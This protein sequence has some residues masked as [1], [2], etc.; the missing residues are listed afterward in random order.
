MVSFSQDEVPSLDGGVGWINSGPIELAKL[1]GKIVLLD[2]WTYCCINCHHVLPA[3]AKLEQKYKNELVVIGVHSGKFNAERNTENIRRKV[4]EY[5][6]KHPVV[7]DA[8]MTIWERFGR[9]SWPTLVLIDPDGQE[10]G[11]NPGEIPF[12]HPRPRDRPGCRELQRPAQPQAAR[13][14]SRDGQGRSAGPLLFPGKVLADVKGKRLFISD[15]G[16]NR[17]VQTDLEGKAPVVIGSGA[18]G[19]VDGGY[20]KARFNRPQGMYLEGETLYV[21]DTENHAIRAVDLKAKHVTTIAGTGSQAPRRPATALPRHGQ[22][23]CAFEPLGR[24]PDSRLASP[25]HRHGRPAPDLEARSRSR[26]DRRLGRLGRREH[27]GRRSAPR[28]VRPA[29]RAGDRR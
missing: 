29:Q 10:I 27:P 25:L 9:Q 17:I 13:V 22:D 18:E 5:R 24:D 16:H 4:A 28:A 7:N 23:Q 26:Q 19:L 11:R 20:D 2:F 21:A 14:R 1:K 8:N 12:E 15:T 3:L 6:I